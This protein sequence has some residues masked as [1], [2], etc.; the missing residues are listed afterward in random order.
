MK[1]LFTTPNWF[2]KKYDGRKSMFKGIT[3]EQFAQMCQKHYDRLH[4]QW[5]L[6]NPKL[7]KTQKFQQTMKLFAQ[8]PYEYQGD[9]MDDYSKIQR[10]SSNGIGYVAICPGESGNNIY[11]EEPHAVAALR[12]KYN[13]YHSNVR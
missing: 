2:S 3:R 4:T 11:I 13:E 9:G 7:T 6:S 5:S 10:P 1:T 12:R 8:I